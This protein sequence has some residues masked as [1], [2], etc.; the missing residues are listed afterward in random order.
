ILARLTGRRTAAMIVRE[1]LQRMG[2]T[3]LKLGQFLAL[4][5]D[6]LPRAFTQ[7]LSKLFESVQPMPP[8]DVR[9]VLESELGGPMQHLVANFEWKP[10]ASASI[11][12]VHEAVTRDGA[13]VAVKIQR[14]GLELLLDADMRNLARLAA[15]VDAIGIMGELSVRDAVRE[16]STY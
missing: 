8:A 7:E 14:R 10:L 3:Y 12:Q 5:M 11:A 9:R 4:R 2:M 1:T 16:F 13:R 15:A 6:L